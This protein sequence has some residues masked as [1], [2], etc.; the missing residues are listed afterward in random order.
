MCIRDRHDDAP[1]PVCPPVDEARLKDGVAH[2]K[3][4]LENGDM[5]ACELAHEE[6]QLLQNAFGQT[7]TA[8]LSA[9]QSFDFER[10][11]KLLHEAQQERT[12]VPPDTLN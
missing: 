2:L 6:S 12:T 4:L 7:G 1:P 11:V 3:E 10:A 9:I 5:A 8:L